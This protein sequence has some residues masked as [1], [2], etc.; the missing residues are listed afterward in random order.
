V[1]LAQG[2]VVFDE[3]CRH[4]DRRWRSLRC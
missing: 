4:A 2:G 3:A 1:C